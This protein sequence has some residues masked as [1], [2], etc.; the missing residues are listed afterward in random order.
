MPLTKSCP[1]ESLA[2][3]LLAVIREHD[4]I[5]VAAHANPDGDAIGSTGAMGCILK[6]MG[7]RFAMYNPSGLPE[8]L[9]WVQ[10][11]GMIHTSLPLLPFKPG[12]VISLDCGDVWR[13][14]SDLAAVFGN[15]PSLCIDHHLGNPQFA[16]L[17]NWVDPGKAATAQMVA[18]VADAAGVP[19]EGILAQCIYLALVT[20]TGS[21]T[22]SNTSAAVFTLAARLLA[23]GLDAAAIRNKLDNQWSLAK[24]RLWGRMM[25]DVRLEHNGQTAICAFDVNTVGSCGAMKE[26]I[27]GFCEKM[28]QIRGVRVAILLRR[29]PGNICKLSM[30]SSGNDDVRAVAS[31][32]GGGGHLNAAG[33]TFS[34]ETFDLAIREVLDA[35]K[36]L[37]LK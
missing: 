29:D 4:N 23:G 14:G 24:F 32:F 13:M 7:K 34:A 17:G 20:D 33:A 12:L 16:S 5:L 28:R 10:L 31:L 27:E 37:S 26:D 2:N 25:G 15:C 8:Y 6:A 21:F 36:R 11:P 22:H 1:D 18:A 3:A 30:R 9:N 19:L 35:V